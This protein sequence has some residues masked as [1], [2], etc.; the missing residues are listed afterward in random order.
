MRY[1]CSPAP[2][3]E[4]GYRMKPLSISPLC[5]F[6]PGFASSNGFL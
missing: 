4:A 5:H 3:G 6:M 1:W 2:G